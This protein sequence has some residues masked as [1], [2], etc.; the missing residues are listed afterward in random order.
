MPPAS[1]RP[2][3]ISVCLADW[4]TGCFATASAWRS[5]P[6]KQGGFI[7]WVSMI[8]SVW[9]SRS[10]GAGHGPW[11]RAYARCRDLAGLALREHSADA[12]TG[13]TGPDRC[14]GVP[15]AHTTG[16]LDIHDHHVMADGRAFVFV[17]TLF[18]LSRQFEPHALLSF[19]LEALSFIS[20]SSLPKIAA[21]TS[22]A[23]RGCRS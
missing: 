4:P 6:I 1:L 18:S 9:L 17:N 19:V 8:R 3:N 14:L 21:A 23:L 15:A 20:P 10:F 22:M 2:V 7:L 12:A 13:N 5:R 16:D 11:A